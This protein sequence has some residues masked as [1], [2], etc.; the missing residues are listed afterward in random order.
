MAKRRPLTLNNDRD[1][2]AAI[3]GFVLNGGLKNTKGLPA[4]GES[5][6]VEI[7]IERIVLPNFQLR[8]YYDRPTIEKIK[9]TIQSVGIQEPLL[10]R[11][12]KDSQDCF[13]LIA[14]SQRKL[15]AEELGLDFVPARI[16]DVDDFTALKISI[17][18][19]EARAD[20]NPYERTRGIIQL[21][22]VGL[23][24]SYDEVIHD[25][26]ALFNA[27]N[28]GTDNNVIVSSTEL[29]FINS[30]FEEMGLN[31]KSFVSNKLQLLRLP[32]DVIAYLENGSLSY[33]KAI[34]IARVKD[35]ELR[36]KLLGQVVTD[37]LS[38]KQVQDLIS[39]NQDNSAKNEVAE[40]RDRSRSILKKA[41][42]TKLLKDKKIRKKVEA[43]TN[44]LEAL[45]LE[46][47]S[48]V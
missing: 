12:S 8:L 35:Q 37:G 10:L 28:R 44:Q 24:K 43:L 2:E 25:L 7:A 5:P 21:L 19:N 30:V 17:I 42:T 15:S 1:T 4:W 48:N 31:W 26:T 11:P 34:R 14:G 22:S 33:T 40:L 13:E 20:I 27:E 46:A 29:D 16:D 23:E 36:Q 47:E 39:Q 6:T 38:V 41:T 45:I 18:E 32:E 9:A 3:E